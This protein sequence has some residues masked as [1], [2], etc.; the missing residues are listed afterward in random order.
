MFTYAIA[1]FC[2]LTAAYLARMLARDMGDG[3]TASTLL[4]VALFTLILGILSVFVVPVMKRIHPWD[5]L[6]REKLRIMIHK[7]GVRTK[8]V[9]LRK[10][11][12]SKSDT[13]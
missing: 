1:A 7:I 9:L 10:S 3:G 11:S 8:R 4:I 5:Y 12:G 13:K 2:I 6:W